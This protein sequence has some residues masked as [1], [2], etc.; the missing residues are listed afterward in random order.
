M[1]QSLLFLLLSISILA[2]QKANKQH[3][4]AQ[5]SDYEGFFNRDS[6]ESALKLLNEDLEF[7]EAKLLK[8]P[9]N[10]S[11]LSKLAGLQSKKFRLDGNVKHIH[12][13]DSIF[14]IV[15]ERNP[16]SNAATYQALAANAITKH[17]FTQ[18]KEYA[19]LALIEGDQKTASY[20]LL[21]DALME[22]GEYDKAIAVLDKQTHK[23][24]FDYLI[25]A[26]KLADHE[27][28]LDL[29]ISIMESAFARTKGNPSLFTWA[30]SNLGDMY[31][32]AGRIE[33]SYN[34]YLEV[35]ASD[36]Q[37]WHSW[38]GIA[39]IS[40]AND[41]NFNEAKKILNFVSQNHNDPQV[42]L[43]LADIAELEQ[44]QTSSLDFKKAYYE[45][46][47][48]PEYLGMY[49]KYLIL[50]EAEDLKMADM[51]ITRANMEQEKRPT[52]EMYDLLAWSYYQNGDYEKALKIASLFVEEQTYEPE[53][54]YHLGLIMKMNDLE[55][56][57][58]F[59][60][61]QA[62]ESTFELGPL[63]TQKIK[64]ALK[65]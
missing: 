15:L 41:G 34:A 63:T 44:D 22:L 47:S 2:C 31:G 57:G 11:Y 42:K 56:K 28:D 24:S 64:Q 48:S 7:W 16:F 26:S 3:R 6:S 51:A 60:L 29:A 43:M 9:T 58:D 53:V 19:G 12:T 49:S 65:S 55:K 46:V 40:L 30:K 23:N 13:S 36:P 62:L 5:I 32:H 35:L 45:Q 20:Y 59:Y 33:D 8:S 52:P 27:G 50:L 38:Q 1:K 18:A 14:K 4:I 21:F 39:W 61:K 10:F 17:E 54:L 37:H 25:R